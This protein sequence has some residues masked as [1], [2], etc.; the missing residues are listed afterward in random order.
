MKKKYYFHTDDDTYE[1][2]P[3]GTELASLAEARWET[4]KLVSELLVNGRGHALLTGGL[5]KVWVTDRPDGNGGILFAL[6]VSALD[7]GPE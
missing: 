1:R 7:G 6:Q 5:L 2:D 3:E 4:I